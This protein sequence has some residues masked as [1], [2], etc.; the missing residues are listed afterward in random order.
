MSPTS[1]D[2]FDTLT[3]T[4]AAPIAA[5]TST[6]F[7]VTAEDFYGNTVTGFA[8]TVTISSTDTNAQ[9]TLPTPSTLTHGVGTFSA[10]LDQ[11]G[12]QTITAKD[13]SFTG[14]SNTI[15]ITPAAL[16]HFAVS[17][18]PTKLARRQRRDSCSS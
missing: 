4:P 2:H 3:G 12:S 10:T 9:T 1:V 7:T 15:I 5:G 14:T 11:A 16:N 17:E 13:G 6:S 18:T 8:G